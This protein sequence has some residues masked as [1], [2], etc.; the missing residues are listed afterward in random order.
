MTPSDGTS[1]QERQLNDV[2]T[3]K[4]VLTEGRKGSR[5]TRQRS[6]VRRWPRPTFSVVI[7][8]R[9]ARDSAPISVGHRPRSRCG[10]SLPIVDACCQHM[11]A[12]EQCRKRLQC[13]RCTFDIVQLPLAMCPDPCLLRSSA[14]P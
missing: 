8:R 4:I 2:N 9:L 6:S 5:V 1:E 7:G 12:T 13:N 10:P 11:K 3:V 14:I